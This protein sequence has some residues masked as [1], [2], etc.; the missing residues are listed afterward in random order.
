MSHQSPSLEFLIGSHLLKVGELDLFLTYSQA[1][2]I[3]KEVSKNWCKKT[4]SER[5]NWYLKNVSASLPESYNFKSLLEKLKDDHVDLRNLLAHSCLSFN[6]DSQDLT[7]Q[8]VF[9]SPETIS[10]A[11]LIRKVKDLDLLKKEIIQ[12]IADLCSQATEERKKNE[13]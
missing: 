11:E 13:T 2:L 6:V 9:G 8:R 3:N 5:I 7:L 10:I 12:S 4:L 1:F